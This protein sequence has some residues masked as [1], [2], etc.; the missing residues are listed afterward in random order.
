VAGGAVQ[1]GTQ[2]A[3]STGRILLGKAEHRHR[4]ADLATNGQPAVHS[5]QWDAGL[6][7]QTAADLAGRAPAEHPHEQWNFEKFL[8]S[9]EGAVVGRFRPRTTPDEDVVVKAI[10]PEIRISRPSFKE[11][12]TTGTP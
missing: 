3:A 4:V 8:V 6:V 5:G 12:S 1:D 11:R 10:E 9:P 2:L 7:E